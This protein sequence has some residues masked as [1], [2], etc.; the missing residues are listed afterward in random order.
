MFYNEDVIDEHFD[1]LN[2]MEEVHEVVMLIHRIINY[3]QPVRKVSIMNDE[4]Q[5][6]NLSFKEKLI[7]R[8]RKQSHELN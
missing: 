5:Q 3:E 7:L 6:D 4:N 1:L 2:V 8:I